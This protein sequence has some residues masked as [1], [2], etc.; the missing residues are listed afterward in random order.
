MFF[1]DRRTAPLERMT[2]GG[3]LMEILL[4]KLRLSCAILVELRCLLL[5]CWP[6]AAGTWENEDNDYRSIATKGDLVVKVGCSRHYILMKH[7]AE[8]TERVLVFLRPLQSGHCLL[9]TFILNIYSLTTFRCMYYIPILYQLC[10]RNLHLVTPCASFSSNT[11]VTDIGPARS[12]QK[13]R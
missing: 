7:T 12:L 10:A 4:V 3:I 8:I 13:V 1:L 6:I 11:Y 2:M 5:P 9:H